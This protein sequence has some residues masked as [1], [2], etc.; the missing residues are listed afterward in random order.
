MLK[1]SR[2][3]SYLKSS[4]FSRESEYMVKRLFSFLRLEEKG[5]VI[6]EPIRNNQ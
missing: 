3:P 1:I 2:A 6:K 5:H 4:L